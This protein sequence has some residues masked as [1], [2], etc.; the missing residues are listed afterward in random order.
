MAD[1]ARVRN[2]ITTIPRERSSMRHSEDVQLSQLESETARAVTQRLFS[3][4]HSYLVI[5]TQARWFDPN[6]SPQ[7]MMQSN[8]DTVR[9]VYEVPFV[10]IALSQSMC[11]NQPKTENSD[12]VGGISPVSSNEANCVVRLGACSTTQALRP[13]LV[14]HQEDPSYLGTRGSLL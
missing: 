14:D 6:Q 8:R 3:S 9:I 2:P 7:K 11:N 12:I 5:R 4:G 10:T 13:V 1:I